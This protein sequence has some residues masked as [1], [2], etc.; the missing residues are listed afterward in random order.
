MRPTPFRKAA[1]PALL[2]F[3]LPGIAL[4]DGVPS[5]VGAQGPRPYVRLQS[6]D[7]STGVAA[8][9]AAARIQ[10]ARDSYVGA[11]QRYVWTEGALY[12]VYAAPGQV[13]D[14]A[15]QPGELLSGA[16]PVAAGDTARWIIGQTES[17]TGPTKQIHI[18]VKPIL[19]DL[20]TNLVINTDRRTYHVELKATARAYMAAVSWAYPQDALIALQAQAAKAE[21]IAP[22]SS[23]LALEALSFGYR[24]DGDKPPWRPT[25][26]FD[27]GR[28]VFIALPASVRQDELP[29]LFVRGPSGATELVNYR[30]TGGYMV[31]D[32]LFDT[33]ELRL[34]DKRAAKVVRIS[35]VGQKARP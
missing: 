2:I 15:L 3:L 11:M 20:A 1:S 30:V 34:G 6:F 29:P 19:P 33:A 12:Q 31:V 27:D 9:N 23:G 26:V 10:P 25:R 21:A 14:I 16:G 4:A 17:G 18:L 13:S 24:I 28:Q 35:R 32:R 8:A 22:V 5:A 7:P